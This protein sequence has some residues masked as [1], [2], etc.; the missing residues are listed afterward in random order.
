MRIGFHP[1]QQADHG[2]SVRRM[3]AAMD[4]SEDPRATA[5]G[6]FEPTRRQWAGYW[7]MI[8]QQTQ[9]AFNDK[10]A[11]FILIPLAAAT[12][13]ALPMGG[14]A[15][16]GVESAAGL[17]IAL[18]F[19]LFA[20]LAGW[21]SDRFSKRDVM[22]AMAI[23]QIGILGWICAGVWMGNF[24]MALAGF[25]AL[26]MQS[27][28][29]S[30]AKI[31]INKELVGSHHLGFAAGIQQMMA[32]LAILIGQV[33]AGWWFDKRYV[34][35]G[36]T[37]DVAGQAALWPLLLLTT[38]AVPGVVLAWVVPRVPAQG[39]APFTAK[40]AVRHFRDL[41]ELWHEP[42]LRRASF[43]VAFFWGFAAYLNL[44]S[45]KVA[46]E[47]TG[48]EAG[49]GTLSSTYMAAASI[50]MVAGF[51][52]ASWLLRRR[53]ELGWVPVAGVAM[54]FGS[55][56]LAFVHPSGMWFLVG[57]G[58]LAFTGAVFL[59]PLNAWM[60][61]NYPPHK[62]GEMQAAVNL[63]DCFAGILA[64]F[65]IT[66]L[67]MLGRA[68]GIDALGG[69]RGQLFFVAFACAAIT[70]LVIRLLP[71]N[72]L[73]LVFLAMVRSFYRIRVVHPERVPKSGGAL[74]LPNH[75]TFADAFFL[76]AACPRPIRFVMDEVFMENRWIRLSARI[77]GTVPIRR[78]QPLDA[79]RVV[80]NA[81]K[82][83][84]V[85]CLFPEGQLSR[86]GTLC[87]LRRGFEVIARKAGHPLV[88]V[89]C[90]G[91]W[92]S[93]FSFERGKAFRKIPYRVPYGLV[94]A[95]GRA[96]DSL[97]VNRAVVRDALLRVSAD[98]M[99]RRFRAPGWGAR[100]P[101]SKKPREAAD[102]ML[103]CGKFIR[104]RI[105]INAHQIGQ[106]N[107]IQRRETIHLLAHDPLPATL[108]S[109]VLAFAELH[110]GR[111]EIHH[112]IPESPTGAWVGGEVLRTAF[113][114][115]TTAAGVRF[116][117]FATDHC[118]PPECDGL[119]HLPC[120]AID[121]VV[122]AMSMPHPPKPNVDSEFQ[123]GHKPGAFGMLA[124]GW[125]CRADD[126]GRLRV[127]GPAAPYSGIALPDGASIDQGGFVF[128]TKFST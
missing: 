115:V 114:K 113:D 73:R 79:I 21:L 18:P 34:A 77:F 81:L 93:V 32:V 35:L 47:I 78:D 1:R 71:R 112:S 56:A 29:F 30:P 37:P 55:I 65:I 43:G 69:L 12:G 98:A 22:L 96:I 45:V 33:V 106:L 20:P 52:F 99:M 90:D 5:S 110:G 60:Q 44:W 127:H 67:E 27:A 39:H 58:A 118:R 94:I 53:I 108:P 68:F 13:F 59:A 14:G 41:R 121:G 91:A 31:G 104:R 92:G 17:M 7:C 10:A 101:R 86:T 75:V 48:G 49:F 2:L 46:K 97:D 125:E 100:L 26:A 11:Q 123:H 107:A 72:F 54:T 50:G 122:V 40:L 70:L 87:E 88:P 63:Q 16:F 76:S 126:A 117:D 116:F 23:A 74:L 119:I 62:R 109:L 105:W 36:A 4:P 24:W 84:E 64:V 3:S 38:L 28:F 61:D 120:L 57:L 124:P 83:G 66:G 95:F 89:W 111:V 85:V 103:R 102:I 15:D 51:G 25:F 128:L 82:N 80:I 42:G 9:N 19:V 8:V 6:A